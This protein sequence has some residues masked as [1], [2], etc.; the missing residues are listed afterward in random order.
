MTSYLG[1][2][3]N[4]GTMTTLT[5]RPGDWCYRT[6]THGHWILTA[7]DS[8]NAANWLPVLTNIRTST[9]A[10]NATPTPNADTDEVYTV[11]SLAVGAVVGLPTGTPANGQQ[12][13][14]RVKDNGTSRSLGWHADYRAIG[15]TLPTATVVG[16]TLYVRAIW[17]SADSKWDVL[18]A[19]SG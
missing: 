13:T 18:T 12:L 15:V 9:V 11:T 4:S 7:A 8:S 3:A 2:A 6:D 16:Q 17:N 5:G 10:S 1:T 19:A 14:I